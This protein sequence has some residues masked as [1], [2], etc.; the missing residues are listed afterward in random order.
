MNIEQIRERIKLTRGLMDHPAWPLMVKDWEEEVEVLKQMATYN[1]QTEKDL[2][3]LRG[4]LDVL[5]RL[6]S[7]AKTLDAIEETLDS[8]EV[9]EE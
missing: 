8:P 9:P 6:V 7:L 4:R 3:F 5:N 2:Y 1:V